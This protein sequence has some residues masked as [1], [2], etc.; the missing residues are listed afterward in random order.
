MCV[1]IYIYIYGKVV[2]SVLKNL[3]TKK[4]L[5]KAKINTLKKREQ[6][7]KGQKEKHD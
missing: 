7:W 6:K 2:Y 4:K 3:R 5:T 1:Y